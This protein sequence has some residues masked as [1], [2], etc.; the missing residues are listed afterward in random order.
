MAIPNEARKAIY[1]RLRDKIE[2]DD[3]I[4]PLVLRTPADMFTGTTL[5]I[6][7]MARDD[8]MSGIS[9]PDLD[10]FDKDRNL[11]VILEVTD[12]ALAPDPDENCYYYARRPE[13]PPP[14]TTPPPDPVPLVWTD[15]THEVTVL[16]RK[17]ITSDNEKFVEPPAGEWVRLAVRHTG[18]EQE[19][20]GGTGNRRFR[21]YGSVFVQVFTEAGGRTLKAD[22]IAQ[23]I[24]DVFD[25]ESFDGLAFEAAFSS[26][27]D[28]EGKWNMAIVEAPFAY[29]EVK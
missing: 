8:L 10:L 1:L 6:A 9:G 22:G 7:E 29:D 17:R 14:P 12:P 13:P 5:A 19:S 11:A 24:V 26:E 28:P 15:V 2:G 20:M 27:G 25:V 21:S 4:F 23:A 18:R 16:D 3:I